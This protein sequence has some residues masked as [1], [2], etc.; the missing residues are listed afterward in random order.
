MGHLD[1]YIIGQEKAKKILAVALYNHYKRIENPV[2]NDIE[3][4]KSNI[5]LI[6]PTGSGKTLLAKTPVCHCG[7]DFFNRSRI[8]GG[9][10][11][12]AFGCGKLQL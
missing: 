4:E 3:L 5:M 7:C 8:C 1:K 12:K 2:Y 10:I 6:G 9:Y 11:I